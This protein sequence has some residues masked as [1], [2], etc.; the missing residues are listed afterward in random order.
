MLGGGKRVVTK[1]AAA[2]F[3]EGYEKVMKIPDLTE[4]RLPYRYLYRLLSVQGSVDLDHWLNQE[5]LF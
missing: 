1:K 2:A 5:I 3:K 4:Y